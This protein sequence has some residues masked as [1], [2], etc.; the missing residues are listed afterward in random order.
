MPKFGKRY[1]ADLEKRHE[2]ELPIGEAVK[3]LKKYNKTKFDQTVEVVM[4]LG[5]DARQADQQIRGAIS[6]PNGIGATKRV[7]AFCSMDKVEE[8][9]A[10][11]ATEAGAEDLVKKIEDGWFD[12]DVAVAEPAMM[13]V[14]A[15]LGRTL[16]PKG[17]MPSPKAGTVNPKVADTVKEFAAGKVEYRN[18]D[19]GNIHGIVGKFSFDD[20]KLTENAEAFIGHIMK[21]KPAST[22]GHYVKKI[23]ISATM[24]PSVLVAE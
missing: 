2:G 14:I 11:G 22:K 12:F 10:A 13:R 20:D 16:G 17:L 8:A 9:K 23:A 5:I 24:T 1:R 19:Y 7:I 18:D 21:L 6:L 4:H 15:K 3:E